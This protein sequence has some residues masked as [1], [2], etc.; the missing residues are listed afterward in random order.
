MIA[1]LNGVRIGYSDTQ[2]GSPVVLLL[3]GYLLNRAMWDPQ[4]G[5]LRAGGARVVAVDLRGFGASEAGPPGP[6]T[7]EQHAD[8]LA[9]L[10]NHLGVDA[11][12]VLCGL[13]MGGYVCFA[14]WRKY[15]D[16]VARLVLADTRATAD[17]DQ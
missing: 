3:H 4:L 15:A 5:P 8:D 1:E 11:P 17:T 14:F 10:L 16:R 12:V 2:S 13:S 9:T 7:M 6:L